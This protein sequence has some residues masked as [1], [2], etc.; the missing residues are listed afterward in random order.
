M[1]VQG[2]IL[3]F[4]IVPIV[5]IY[6]LIKVGGIIGVGWTIF[7]VVATAVAGAA[8]LRQQGLATLSRVTQAMNKGELPALELLEGVV[9]LIGGALLL[10]PGFFTDLCGFI[11]LFPVTRKHLLLGLMQRGVQRFVVVRPQRPGAAGS[12]LNGDFTRE[13]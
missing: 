5:E 6:L 9:I 13:D 7:A 11:C 8:L 4:L 3:I 10:T 2:L 1:P 12:T